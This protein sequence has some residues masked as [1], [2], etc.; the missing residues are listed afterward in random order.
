MTNEAK[1]L[2]E[3]LIEKNPVKRIGLDGVIKNQWF[4]TQR[5]TLSISQEDQMNI[6][7][8]LKERLSKFA[9]YKMA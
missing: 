3:S 8:I 2:I 1:K 9:K 4:N 7:I 5:N 6:I